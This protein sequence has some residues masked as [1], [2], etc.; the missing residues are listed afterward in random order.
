[1]S[2][3]VWNFI[4]RQS[5]TTSE[6]DR[7]ITKLYETVFQSIRDFSG[8][9]YELVSSVELLIVEGKKTSSEY[10]YFWDW[11]EDIGLVKIR[12]IADFSYTDTDEFLD[13]LDFMIYSLTEDSRNGINDI[14]VSSIAD[15]IGEIYNYV[16]AHN[17]ICA[18]EP[19]FNYYYKMMVEN[20]SLETSGL[21]Y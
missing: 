10:E 19:T 6:A 13:L 17:Y 11:M 5:K 2:V 7:L 20:G 1:M 21:F 14:I 15:V 8:L 9:D 18:T 16:L 3:N 4:G 12:E